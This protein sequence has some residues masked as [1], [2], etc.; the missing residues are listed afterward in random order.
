LFKLVFFGT[1]G[2]GR[3][4]RWA[5]RSEG[6]RMSSVIRSLLPTMT[7]L[8]CASCF[9]PPTTDTES[10]GLGGPT[11]SADGKVLDPNLHLTS[12]L[13]EPYRITL[14]RESG[15]Q[16]ISRK[17]LPGNS[18]LTI[19]ISNEHLL[20]T[21]VDSGRVLLQTPLSTGPNASLEFEGQV[22][23]NED[24]GKTLVYHLK[25]VGKSDSDTFTL[26]VQCNMR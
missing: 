8:A 24:I 9:N 14:T 7:A 3:A 21:T 6:Y 16:L 5:D 2:D 12:Q 10:I 11:R 13:S 1:G 15:I 20:I 17:E 25:A 18:S 19:S 26:T 4:T 22:P 23:S